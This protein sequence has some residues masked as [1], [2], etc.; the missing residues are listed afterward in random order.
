MRLCIPFPQTCNLVEILIS[1][2][3]SFV[4]DK[5]FSLLKC[6]TPFGIECLQFHSFSSSEL[7][8][9]IFTTGFGDEYNFLNFRC[10]DPF[11]V[12]LNVSW[13][14]KWFSKIFWF[15]ECWSD[16]R[17]WRGLH[18]DP[19]KVCRWS[20]EFLQPILGIKGFF[21]GGM[22]SSFY[23]DQW[24]DSQHPPLMYSCKYQSIET[25][26]MISNYTG[27]RIYRCINKIELEPI[28]VTLT[29][30]R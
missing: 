17:A 3:I 14:P 24:R 28:Y 12:L 13:R 20:F 27:T 29:T 16:T 23:T 26:I 25:I 19:L 18:I 15:S 22:R 4:I 9:F 6:Q 11:I 30:R 2:K 21:P 10:E 5:R 7:L 1:D 8:S